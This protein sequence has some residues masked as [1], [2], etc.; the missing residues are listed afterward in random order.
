MFSNI[1]DITEAWNRD[2]VKE[3]SEKIS[4]GSFRTNTE[5][6]QIYNLKH[7]KH[8]KQTEK[9]NFDDSTDIVSLS[10]PTISLLSDNTVR[11]S[12]E[13]AYG[14]HDNHFSGSYAPVN[15]DKYSKKNRNLK[16][17]KYYNFY[18]ASDSDISEPVYHS[19][20]DFSV[21]HLRKCNLCYNRL[22]KL[23]DSKV[24]EKFD[25]ILLDTKMKQLQNLTKLN[26]TTPSVQHFTQTGQPNITTN[27]H[28]WKETLIIVIGAI[29]AMFIVFLIVK[30]VCHK[31]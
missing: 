19:K 1:S 13:Y 4:K 3:I 10:D 29:I 12:S 2:P 28:S 24:N 25:E 21:K 7:M 27:Q 11:D 18:H 9:K 30:S 22:Q 17:N 26:A 15:F 31:G 6:S 5:Q 23:V 14:H 8:N 16:N 20:C